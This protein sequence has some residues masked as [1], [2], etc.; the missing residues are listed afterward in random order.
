MMIRVGDTIFE[1]PFVHVDYYGRKI[2][3]PVPG[4]IVWI[5]P[6][7]RYYVVEFKWPGGGS[8]REA[9]RQGVEAV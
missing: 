1:H 3:Q 5:H 8:Y 9:F 4:K 7:K 2:Y 6:R